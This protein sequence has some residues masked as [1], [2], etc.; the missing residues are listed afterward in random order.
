VVV[1]VDVVDVVVVMVVDVDVVVGVDV[2]VDVVVVVVVNVVVVTVAV[3]GRRAGA[4]R[5]W[6][7]QEISP[8]LQRSPCASWQAQ[9]GQLPCS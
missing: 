2:D 1:L 3:A 9:H 6:W 8:I 4:R 5:P 7:W